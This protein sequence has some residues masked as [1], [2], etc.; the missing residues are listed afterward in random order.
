VGGR[1]AA[2]VNDHWD[3]SEVR[4]RALRSCLRGLGVAAEIIEHVAGRDAPA[5]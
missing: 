5:R 1:S 4:E 3:R 2:E